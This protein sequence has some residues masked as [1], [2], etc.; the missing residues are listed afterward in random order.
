MVNE[1][2]RQVIDFITRSLKVNKVWKPVIEVIKQ[3]SF[4][5]DRNS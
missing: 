5:T 4:A 2:G 1:M 3:F